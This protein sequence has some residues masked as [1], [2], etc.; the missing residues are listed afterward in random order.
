MRL[1]GQ[2]IRLRHRLH[3]EPRHLHIDASVERV[4]LDSPEA[5]RRSRQGRQRARQIGVEIGVPEPHEPRELLARRDR[6]L[7]SVNEPG[8]HFRCEHL[9]ARLIELV[10]RAGLF[11]LPGEVCRS[12]GT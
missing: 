2:A 12:F 9:P 11:E 1:T 6:L 8:V 10:H 7:A 3:F 5:S 4:L